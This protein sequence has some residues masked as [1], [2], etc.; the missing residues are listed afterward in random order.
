MVVHIRVAICGGTCTCNVC[1]MVVGGGGGV[2]V[3][4]CMH[5]CVCACSPVC[6]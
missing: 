5:V 2:C 3:H 4:V 1:E 6:A